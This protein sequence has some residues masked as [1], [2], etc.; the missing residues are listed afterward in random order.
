MWIMS[1]LTHDWILPPPPCDRTVSGSSGDSSSLPRMVPVEGGEMSMIYGVVYTG[2]VVLWRT[3][4][5]G[6]P[7]NIVEG[8][9]MALRTHLQPPPPPFPWT[10]TR[11]GGNESSQSCRSSFL[12]IG[13]APPG[14]AFLD[15]H[16][17][18]VIRFV[19]ILIYIFF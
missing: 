17:L 1:E 11:F 9:F 3:L 8:S 19:Q 12:R 5:Y 15:F 16:R 2:V 18:N 7:S 10:P 4:R 6:G 14:R 13:A